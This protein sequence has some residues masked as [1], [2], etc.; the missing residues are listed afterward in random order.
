[1]FKQLTIFFA[2]VLFGMISAGRTSPTLAQ[3]GFPRYCLEYPADN[4]VQNCGF[5]AGMAN[6]TPFV[7][8]GAADV[9]TIDGDRCHTIHHPCGYIS[10]A[11]GFTAGL[12]QQIPVEPG[13]IYDANVQL[14]LYDSYD[15]DDGGVGRKIGLDPTGGTDPNS[16]NIVWSPEVWAFDH[17]HK[18]VFPE[19]QVQATAQSGTMTLFV[20]VNN[21]ARV[22]SPIFQVWIDEIGM[23]K[24]GQAEPTATPI[25]PT[26]TPVPP[27]ATPTPTETPMPTMTPSATATP[28][29]TATPIP[30]TATPVPPTATPTPTATP[31][32]PTA[33]P[34]PTFTPTPTIIAVAQSVLPMLGGGV[35]CFGGI[36]L[37]SLAVVTVVL[38]WL[39]KLGADETS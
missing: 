38:R 8:A 15:K 37:V 12:Y 26:A 5:D 33:T 19:L 29:A 2:V 3:G 7:I 10:S 25:P 13:G 22:P 30:S 35:V 16:P 20:W 6:W 18:L 34:R 36:F 27:T 17:A 24:I 31:V 23:I 14:V 39:Y 32:P 21:R 9:S 1:M 4:L 28:T 11:G